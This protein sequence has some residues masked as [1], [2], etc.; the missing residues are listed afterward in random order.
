MSFEI[1]LFIITLLLIYRTWVIFVILLLP[2]STWVKTRHNHNIVLQSEKEAEN[3]QYISLSLT[4]YIRKFVGN[5]FLS[6][7]RYSQFQVSKIPS[8]HVRLW[9]YRHVYCAKIESEAVV[10]F[11]TELRGS[12]NLII[13]KGCIVGDN[14]IL[15]ARRGGIELG[16]NVN[17][18]SNVSFYT[19]SH[20]YNDPYFSASVSKVG[21]IKVGNRA[22]I[23]SNA[24]ILH[25]VQI[26]EG[27]V[28][29]A[30]AVVTKDVPPFTVVGGI[31]AKI[32][33]KRSTNLKYNFS[34]K[35]RCMFY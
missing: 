1:L 33:G 16:E 18:G 9:L 5:I 32:I 6:Y 24:I 7:Y 21:G 25:D 20:D 11:G 35:N 22:W 13:R 2:L 28:V 4:D 29:A 31:P 19:D 17:I 15:D 3:A 10:Y 30:G 27:A 12:W 34:A 23:G 8:H 26:G 14:C